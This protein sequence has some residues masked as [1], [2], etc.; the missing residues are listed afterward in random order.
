MR[1]LGLLLALLVLIPGPAMAGKKKG[2][3][4]GGSASASSSNNN[5]YDEAAASAFAPGGVCNNTGG[6]QGRAFGF[7]LNPSMRLYC[8]KLLAW[9]VSL[10]YQGMTDESRAIAKSMREQVNAEETRLRKC[11]TFMKCLFLLGYIPPI[12]WVACDLWGG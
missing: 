7:S 5:D 11:R 10:E 3:G 12:R 6:G 8:K 1:L 2:G 4:G 9:Q